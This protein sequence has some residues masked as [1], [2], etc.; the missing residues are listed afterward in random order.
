MTSKKHVIFTLLLG[1]FFGV[2][3][4]GCGEDEEEPEVD[5]T[6]VIGSWE[7]ESIN[8]KT[9]QQA[10]GSDVEEQ[11]GLEQKLE[12]VAN[13]WKFND[14]GTWSW[15]FEFK[16][17]SKFS[18]P[19]YSIMS[20]QD[21]SVNGTYTVDGA[22]M[23]VTEGDEK[24]NAEVTLDPAEL[25]ESQGFNAEVLEAQAEKD[26]EDAS[27]EVVFDGEIDCIWGVQ[28]GILTLT[29]PKGVIFLKRK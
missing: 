27:S 28:D 5:E 18:D 12:L 11:E 29:H 24:L 17:E 23:T 21:Y 2:I 10:F 4:I 15:Y 19:V 22:N 20:H 1:L 26:L 13:D 7:I 8:G 25:L 6:L 14:D 3:I 9:F 16:T